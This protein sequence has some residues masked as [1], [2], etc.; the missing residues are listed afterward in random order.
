MAVFY[1]IVC[2]RLHEECGTEDW[3]FEHAI[4]IEPMLGEKIQLG[5]CNKKVGRGSSQ[6]KYS[7]RMIKDDQAAWKQVHSDFPVYDHID[8]F[9]LW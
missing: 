2:S 6:Y 8:R 3:V 7:R 1:C 9:Q 5:M 4:Y